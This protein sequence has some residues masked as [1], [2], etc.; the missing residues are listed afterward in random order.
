MN[1]FRFFLLM[2]EAGTAS[3]NGAVR[4]NL[5]NEAY[6]H[7]T[8]GYI[9]IPSFLIAKSAKLVVGGE[10]VEVFEDDRECIGYAFEAEEVGR[11]LQAG[12]TES[13]TITL[14]ESIGI[15]NL[16]DKVRGQWE[17]SCCLNKLIRFHA[18][19]HSL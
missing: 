6:I 2:K 12:F 13:P 5:T 9:Q 16:L 14:A 7:G 15:M 17:F 8:E 18:D 19:I 10:E 1:S 11:C 4:L 3:L